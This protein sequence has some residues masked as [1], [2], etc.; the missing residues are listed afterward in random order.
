MSPFRSLRDYERFVYSLQS[1]FTGIGEST[2]V[3]LQRSRIF[4]EVSGELHFRNGRRMDVYERLTW[5]SGSIMLVGYSYSVWKGPTQLYW[6]DSQPHPNDPVLAV[7]NP[8]HKH[9]PPDPKQHRLPAPELSFT[10]PNLPF[11]IGEACS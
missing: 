4:A 1:H 11:L 8:H 9:V 7:T 6:Y 10:A 3:V 2:L 5:D